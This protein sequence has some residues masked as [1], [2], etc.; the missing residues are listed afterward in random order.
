MKA[1]LVLNENGFAI[2]FSYEL[3]DELAQIYLKD[4]LNLYYKRDYLYKY[5]CIYSNVICNLCYMTILLCF[6]WFKQ[7][8]R[9]T[10]V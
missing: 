1:Y 4:M 7:Y 2:S 10:N 5:V 8:R 9:L 3:L 6:R